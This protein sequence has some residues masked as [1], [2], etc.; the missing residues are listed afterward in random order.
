[1]TH[2]A[3][4]ISFGGGGGGGSG[5][6][7]GGFSSAAIFTSHAPRHNRSRRSSADDE[8][9]WFCFAI[10]YLLGFLF[11][12]V[13]MKPR[14][15]IILTWLYCVLGASIT[16]GLLGKYYSSYST[17]ASPTDMRKVDRISNAFC[18]SVSVDASTPITT[19][20]L[21]NEPPIND[22]SA[23]LYVESVKT[24]LLRNTYEYWGFYL[25]HGSVAT[26]TVCPD[27]GM[28]LYII[29]GKANLDTWIE[30]SLCDNCYERE[31][32]VFGCFGSQGSSYTLT[33]YESDQ[34]FFLFANDG[35]GVIGPGPA[36]AD[37]TFKLNRRLYDLSGASVVC[38]N[39][40]DCTVPLS[41]TAVTIV[42]EVP[43]SSELDISIDITCHARWYIYLMLFLVIP[44]VCGT[45]VT[46]L[47]VKCS[48]KLDQERPR[49]DS[50]VFVVSENE[51]L[52]GFAANDS[53]SSVV[54]QPPS[55]MEAPPR[56]EDVVSNK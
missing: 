41:I 30:N 56:Y 2:G 20:K 24:S 29:R 43:R 6:S 13:K 9:C 55:Y 10:F 11:C 15:R 4:A 32:F 5:F 27:N 51:Q 22:T 35:S 38:S 45:L 14:T 49:S 19:Y 52:R 26:A 18:E 40:R 47:I 46:L 44:S 3:G 48:R 39:D 54:V 53:L 12:I 21:K 37:I 42:F 16:G 31:Y 36:A 7:G 50:Q 33:A 23:E 25:L 34:Y 8:Q 17:S 28:S 1:M